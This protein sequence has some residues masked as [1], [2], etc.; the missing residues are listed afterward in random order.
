MY[1]LY[2]SDHFHYFSV[3]SDDG[4]EELLAAAAAVTNPGTVLTREF[5]LF[6]F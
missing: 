3:G 5:I 2:S 4:H 1:V 6:F